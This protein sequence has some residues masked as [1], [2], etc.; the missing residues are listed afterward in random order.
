MKLTFVF[1]LLIY[2]ATSSELLDLKELAD[3][4][5]KTCTDIN[6]CHTCT[7]ANCEWSGTCKGGEKREPI[8]IS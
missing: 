2:F 3:L 5:K 6:E 1:A 7:L 8:S 4:T